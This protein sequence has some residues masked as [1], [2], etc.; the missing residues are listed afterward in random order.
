MSEPSDPGKPVFRELTG[1]IADRYEIQHLV[2]KGAM[3][4]V[5]KARDTVLDRPVALKVMAAQIADDP[6]LN[7][8]FVREAKAVARMTHPNV[9]TVFDL[10]NLPDGSPYIA[11]EFLDGVDLQKAVRQPGGMTLE[12]KAAVIVQVLRGLGHAH[13]SGIVHRDIKPANIFIVQKDGSVKIMD[14]GVAHLSSHTMTADGN[15]V[16]TADYMSPEQVKGQKVDTRTDLFSVGCMLFELV[17]GRRPFHSDNLMAIFYKITHEEPNFELIPGG[18]EYD[19][20]LPILKKALAKDINK[21]YQTAQEF[22]VDLREWLRA[23]ATTE[24]TQHVLESLVDLETPTHVPQPLTEAPRGTAA[25]EGWTPAG[26]TVELG[27][28]RF[29]PGRRGLPGPTQV[30]RRTVVEARGAAASRAGALHA[31][32]SPPLARPSPR[33]RRVR[34]SSPLPWVLLGLGLAGAAGAGGFFY[35]K[36]QQETKTPSTTL[37]AAPPVTEAPA[38]TTLAVP[39]PP[40]VT[41]APQPRFDEAKGRAAASVRDAQAAFRRGDYDRA[42]AS[43]QLALKEEADDV[44]ARDVLARALEGQKATGRL[45]AGNAAL[46]RGELDRADHEA[47]AAFGIAPWDQGVADLKKRIDAARLRATQQAEQQAEQQ[48]AVEINRLLDRGTTA[49][50]NKEYDAALTAYEAVLDLD[51]NNAAAQNGKTGAAGAKALAEAAASGRAPAA[52]G[53][54]FVAGPTVARSVQPPAGKTPAGFMDTPEVD[55]KRASQAAAL[56]GKLLFEASPASPKPGDRYSV[57]AYLLNEG[58]QPIELAT[59]LVTT[60]IN[61]RKSQGPVTPL[62]SV[63]APRQRARVF[64]SPSDLWKQETTAWSMEIELHTSTSEIYRSTLTWK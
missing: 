5:Y 14:F 37:A 28:R 24:S 30:G 39:A 48:R 51:P 43:A 3:G 18:A 40:P 29:P 54:T 22:A 6:E 2:G 52:S 21:R 33:A 12:R 45:R 57:S 60:T 25:G 13:D 38:P 1:R 58:S 7:Q 4:H 41:A 62:V 17:A 31:A 15:I 19:A 55:V 36:G 50:Q 34:R 8:R 47:Q 42:V 56:P 11:M 10:G 16:G 23:H 63:V 32:P 49:L 35:W 53:R 26:A 46:E 59:M 44:Q 27:E 61:G 9:V 20:L 64:Q